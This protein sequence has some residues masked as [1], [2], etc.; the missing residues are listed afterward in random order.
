MNI[1][2]LNLLTIVGISSCIKHENCP[3]YVQIPA[4]ITPAQSAYHL[5][6]TIS[7][8]SKFYKDVKAFNSE[9]TELIER[10]DAGNFVW[11]PST[12]I[13]RIDTIGLANITTIDKYFS[14]VED[15]NYN[16]H[17]FVESDQFSAMDGQYNYKND[18]FDLRIRLIPK[19][20]G[21]YFILQKSGVGFF[22][23]QKFPQK[24]PGLNVEA[25]VQMNHA[26]NNNIELL[27]ESP[28][29]FFNTLILG[30]PKGNFYDVGGYCFKVIP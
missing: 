22:G 20:I 5:G 24:C 18:T 29:S 2:Y 6:D 12:S 19:K 8:I 25:W 21:T 10:I 14:L 17:M 3:R 15:S 16:Y 1:L 28:D 27:S 13:E 7:I 9:Y 30:N 23:N 4:F 26:E 11:D